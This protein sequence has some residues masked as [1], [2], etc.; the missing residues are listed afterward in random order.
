MNKEKFFKKDDE[1]DLVQE[2]LFKIAEHYQWKLEA[3]AIFANH[4]HFIARSPIE[5]RNLGKFINHLHSLT[6]RKINELHHVTGRKVWY[7]Y[8]DTQLTFQKSYLARLNYVM[9]N[10]VK[11]KLVLQADQY[12]WCS[13]SWFKETSSKAYRQSVL[14]FNTDEVNVS[15]EF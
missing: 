14:S 11:H 1:L 4:Y 3:W 15:D 13:A 12:R 7:Q 6:A 10:S 2:A 8:W 5:S 9:N